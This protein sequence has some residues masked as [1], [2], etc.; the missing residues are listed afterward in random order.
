MKKDRAKQ[1][2]KRKLATTHAGSDI[3][4]AAMRGLNGMVFIHIAS[5]AARE[6]KGVAE[7]GWA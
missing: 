2:E 5:A 6:R 1:V 7:V 3:G 4:L